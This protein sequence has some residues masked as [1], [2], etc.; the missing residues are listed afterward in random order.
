MDEAMNATPD[1]YMITGLRANGEVL[2]ETEANFV[3]SILIPVKYRGYKIESLIRDGLV[4]M[5]MVGRHK[6]ISREIKVPVADIAISKNHHIIYMNGVLFPLA[7]G[8]AEEDKLFDALDGKGL[9][10]A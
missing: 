10:N 6:Q 3:E 9:N 7:D 8:L 5:R 4:H 2:W 1:K